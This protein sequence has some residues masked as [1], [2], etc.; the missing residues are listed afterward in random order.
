MR[1]ISSWERKSGRSNAGLSLISWSNPKKFR[2]S[3]S[4]SSSALIKWIVKWEA[5]DFTIWILS[6]NARLCDGWAENRILHCPR[7]F[8]LKTHPEA[9]RHQCK[10]KTA[11]YLPTYTHTPF[12]YY[13][14]HLQWLRVS[15]RYI[16]TRTRLLWTTTPHRVRWPINVCDR[17]WEKVTLRTKR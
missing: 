16:D 8:S 14:V 9:K 3:Q 13:K 4:C 7:S 5:H 10:N 15:T 1:V 6:C 17:I 2:P 12:M 11:P